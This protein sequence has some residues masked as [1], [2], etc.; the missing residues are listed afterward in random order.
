MVSDWIKSTRHGFY[1]Y[2]ISK[3]NLKKN[4]FSN[5]ETLPSFPLFEVQFP[6]N[7][8]CSSVGRSFWRYFLKGE[9]LHFHAH[10]GAL[11]LCIYYIAG[12]RRYKC[13]FCDNN[14]IYASHLKRHIL[15][16]HHNYK[17]PKVS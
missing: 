14:F 2:R 16:V 6:Y 8:S 17:N 13:K 7:P 3:T 9:K 4:E 1:N 10:L 15:V 11:V 5:F 12:I